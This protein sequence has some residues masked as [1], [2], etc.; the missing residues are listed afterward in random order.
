MIPSEPHYL[1]ALDLKLLI[2][3]SNQFYLCSVMFYPYSFY[4]QLR[5]RFLTNDV[6]SQPSFLVSTE[7]NHFKDF[8]LAALF[9][10]LRI[11]LRVIVMFSHVKM[12]ISVKAKQQ[13]QAKYH[14]LQ[15][16]VGIQKQVLL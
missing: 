7:L 2:S 4:S 12:V 16:K 13:M 8:S 9:R 6:F 10:F 3:T 14:V 11:I 5:Q 15:F 1:S